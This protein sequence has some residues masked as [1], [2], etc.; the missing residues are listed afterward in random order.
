M[1][2]RTYIPTSILTRSCWKKWP[3]NCVPK[4]SPQSR[5]CG[6]LF[7]L[8]GRNADGV[9]NSTVENSVEKHDGISVS[10]SA[11]DGSAL[12]TGASAGAFVL[13]LRTNV[14]PREEPG[15]QSQP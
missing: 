15:T 13:Q 14:T 12:C 2:C 9:F 3:A 10:D 4:D 1:T 8:R 7:F 11:R 5:P 6:R